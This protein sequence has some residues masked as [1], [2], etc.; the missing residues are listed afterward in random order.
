MHKTSPHETQ[1]RVTT[2]KTV[3]I[4][5]ERKRVKRNHPTLSAPGNRHHAIRFEFKRKIS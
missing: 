3:N 5:C 4:I 2:I 1:R